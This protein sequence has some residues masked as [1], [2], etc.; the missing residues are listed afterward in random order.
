M[1]S[2]MTMP[3]KGPYPPTTAGLGGSPTKT[4]DDPIT[5]VF[6]FL[7]LCG[8][9][10]HMTILQINITRGKK[11]LMSGMTFGF[12]TAR[13][14][15]C[16]MR[17][18]WSTHPTNIS[19]AIAAQ[20]FI[21]A[22]VIVLFIINLIFTQRVLRACHPHWAWT[23]SFS[24]AF[25][26]YYASIVIMLIALITC[27]VQSFYTLSHNTRRID[28]D[29]Q[30]VGTTY[31]AAAAFMPLPLLLLVGVLPKQSRVEKFGQGRFR[32]K[33]YVLVFSALLLSLGAAFRAGIAY[34][35]KPAAHPAWYHSKACFYIFNF[36]I[37]FTIVALYA[38]IRVDKRFHVPNGS[39]GAGDY[40]GGAQRLSLADRVMSEEMVFDDEPSIDATTAEKRNGDVE[41]GTEARAVEK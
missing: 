24:L 9:I 27:T 21:A 12:C 23:R 16:T 11:F 17:L 40:S 14:V 8:A 3:S 2:P 5:A 41:A 26:L 6:L 30:L 15:A 29:V 38:V 18:V 33:V 25:K 28:R 34:V 31:F 35:P 39:H 7:F 4:L 1:S 20:I 19:I 36:T 13:I 22:G 10:T 37:E 32:T